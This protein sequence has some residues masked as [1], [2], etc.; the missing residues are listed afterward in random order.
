MRHRRCWQ[1]PQKVQIDT[2]VSNLKEGEEN[3][4]R[5]DGPPNKRR[6]RWVAGGCYDAAGCGA[7]GCGASGWEAAGCGAGAKSCAG[8]GWSGASSDPDMDM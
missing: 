4:R 6:V 8:S 2:L 5:L 7:A 3:P 1:A